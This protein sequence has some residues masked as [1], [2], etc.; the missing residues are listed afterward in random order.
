MSDRKLLSRLIQH[1]ENH[2]DGHLTIM[3]FTTNWRVG[4]FTPY[5][6]DDVQD[7]NEGRTFEEAAKA[8]LGDK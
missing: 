3:K 5:S 1:A 7:L 2:S 8:A 6:H 4:F